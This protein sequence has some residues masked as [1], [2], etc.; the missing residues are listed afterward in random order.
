MFT[1]DDLIDAVLRR[2]RAAPGRRPDAALPAGMR[3]PQAPA[4]V[5]EGEPAG[6]GKGRGL[7]PV[8]GR[9]FLTERELKNAL[10][11]GSREITI[12]KGAIVSPLAME[13]L[14]LKGIE[15]RQG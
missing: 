8:P 6:P 14:V 3:V 13:W 12:P 10:T 2:V 1:R 7:P 15:V 9:R 11:P 4:R 5:R